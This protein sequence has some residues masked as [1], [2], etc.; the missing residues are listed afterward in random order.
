MFDFKRDSPARTL[1]LD[2]KAGEVVS[3]QNDSGN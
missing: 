1:V 3:S 2:E